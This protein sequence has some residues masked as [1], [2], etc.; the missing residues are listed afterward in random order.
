MKSQNK[1]TDV[2]NTN[3][4]TLFKSFLKKS[5]P[6]HF[7]SCHTVS[8]EEMPLGGLKSAMM[9]RRLSQGRSILVGAMC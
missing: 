7:T 3:F 8:V 5:A 4:V 9:P 6:L 2:L 1:A